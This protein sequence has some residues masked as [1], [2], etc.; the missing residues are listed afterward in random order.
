MLSTRPTLALSLLLSFALVASLLLVPA[1]GAAGPDDCREASGKIAG[2][3]ARSRGKQIVRCNKADDC[4]S[5]KLAA[6]IARLR[7]KNAAKLTTQCASV[8]PTDIGMGASCPDPTGRCTHALD[9]NAALVECIMCLVE[10]TIEP[11]LRRLQGDASDLAETCGGCAGT[12]CEGGFVCEMPP[13]HC[14]DDPTVGFCIEVPDVCPDIFAPVCGCDGRTYENDCVRRQHRAAL[15]HPGPCQT[16]CGD[17]TGAAC[18]D[19]TFCN[20]LPGRCEATNEGIC[21]PIPEACPDVWDPVC[22]CDGVTYSNDCDREAAAVRL[23]HF[24]ACDTLCGID[25]SG[26]AEC[27]AG[28]YCEQPPGLCELPGI[29]GVCVPLPDGCPDHIEPV[30]GCDRVT[31]G[32]DCERMTAGVALLHHGECENVCG[33]FAGLPCDDGQVCDLPPGLCHTA[34]LQG[35]CVEA[36][37]VCPAIADP[38]C[39]CDGV[40]YGNDCERRRAGAQL[41]HFGACAPTCNPDVPACGPAAVCLTPPGLCG[42]TDEAECVPVPPECPATGFPVCGCDGQTYE[43]GCAAVQAGVGIAH[44]GPCGVGEPCLPGDACGPGL[45]CVPLPGLCDASLDVA[46][47]CLPADAEGCFGELGVVCGCNGETYESACDAAAVGVGIEHPGPCFT[48]E[49]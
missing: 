48:E 28:Q 30:C 40:T 3:F 2:W 47:F 35:H 33:G 25:A 6:K 11:L 45:T 42:L 41:A 26:S 24:G 13:G 8:E 4:D 23:R 37:E 44:E 18:P 32:N 29:P 17:A 39:G 20:G 36:P 5:A 31:Y 1:A 7:Q 16:F 21:T 14:H 38:V 27:P 43:G 34:D 46:G 15:F 10:E 19:G 49:P 22:G 12:P 9:S